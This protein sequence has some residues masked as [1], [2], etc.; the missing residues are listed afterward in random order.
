MTTEPQGAIPE[1]TLGWRLQMALAHG[2]ASS[3]LSRKL[4]AEQLGYEESALSRWMHDK[5]E[6]RRG[7]LAQWALAC[8]VSQRWLETGVGSPTP[9]GEP[10]KKEGLARLAARKRARHA[11]DGTNH[12]YAA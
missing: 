6:P 2:K 4:L 1:L 11:G 5:G 10:T 12:W 7:V 9:P 3:G 8:G